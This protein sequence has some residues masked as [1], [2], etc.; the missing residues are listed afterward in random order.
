LLRGIASSVNSV[1][2]VL[3]Q[4]AQDS[5]VDLAVGRV[6]A[7]NEAYRESHPRV[8][9]LL[10]YNLFHVNITHCV[11]WSC[12]TFLYMRSRQQVRRSGDMTQS[13]LP[14]L[15]KGTMVGKCSNKDKDFESPMD[16][17]VADLVALYR[18]AEAGE[19]SGVTPVTGT[20]SADDFDD[21]ALILDLEEELTKKLE[22]SN[23]P[24]DMRL[25]TL[26]IMKAFQ[27]LRGKE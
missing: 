24:F 9:F 21:D 7:G 26:A 10:K 25:F 20:K 19:S 4:L 1:A 23:E 18:P 13:G 22:G 17:I 15:S 14:T 3:S 8:V 2:L 6:K 16:E 27:I 11:Q 12:F 5:R